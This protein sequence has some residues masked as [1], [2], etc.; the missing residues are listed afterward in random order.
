[1]S[2]RI[3]VVEEQSDNR[4]IIRDTLAGT[5]YE[6]IEAENG[7]EAL[8]AIAKQRPRPR[9]RSIIVLHRRLPLPGRFLLRH[10]LVANGPKRPIL[11]CNRMSA[12]RGIAT[13]AGHAQKGMMASGLVRQ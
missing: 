2:K 9:R 4:K 1:V 5:D 10:T 13:V 3:L 7:E 11:R 8:A 6:I 12:F